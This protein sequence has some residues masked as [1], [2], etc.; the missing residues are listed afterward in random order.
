MG[1]VDR[2]LGG[3]MLCHAQYE[4]VCGISVIYRHSKTLSVVCILF[5]LLTSVHSHTKGRS[6]AE[7]GPY[8]L[9][10]MFVFLWTICP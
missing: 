3:P 8:S 1:T 2:L 10:N 5:E 4:N 7:S 9:K 6:R